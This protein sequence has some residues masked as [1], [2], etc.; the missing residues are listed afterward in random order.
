M[1]IERVETIFHQT[2]GFEA[3]Y[4]KDTPTIGSSI[5]MLT[6]E[7]NRACEFLM[8]NESELSSAVD[9]I[10]DIFE[11][12]ALPYFETFGTVPAID[13]ELNFSPATPTP[14]RGSSW[15]RCATGAIVARLNGRP[16]YYELVHAYAEQ[17]RRLS[18]GFYSGRFEALLQSLET[19]QPDELPPAW[20]GGQGTDP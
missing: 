17:M 12:F 10:V 11:R 20:T 16:D 18:K 2:S 13:K 8:E 1:R 3:K 9:G 19:V 4:Q 14:H 15:L 5:G 7:N 6:A